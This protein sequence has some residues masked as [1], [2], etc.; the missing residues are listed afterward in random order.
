MAGL[1][2]APLAYMTASACVLLRQRMP[3]SA[4][5]RSP[6]AMTGTESFSF[7]LCSSSQRACPPKP[8]FAVRGCR[9]MRPAPAS[10]RRS[11]ISSQLHVSSVMPSLSLKVTCPSPASASMALAHCSA[12]SGSFSMADPA[13]WRATL[14]TEHPILRSNQAN[15]LSHSMAV[16]L[17]RLA[18]SLPNSCTTR[19]VSYWSVSRMRQVSLPAY[20]SP[21]ALTISVT[22]HFAPYSRHNLRKGR[23]V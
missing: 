1:V 10:S 17:P 19:G 9:V 11:A 2:R 7:A 3:S 16:A 8:C 4:V 22:Q 5:K 13:P 14:G 20:T 18:A 12:L 15:P 23:S 21:L 6:E